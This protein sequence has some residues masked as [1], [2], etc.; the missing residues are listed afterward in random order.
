MSAAA[1]GFYKNYWAGDK[2]KLI[3]G[4]F[5]NNINHLLLLQWLISSGVVQLIVWFFLTECMIKPSAWPAD[6]L[7]NG[8]P[9]E[10][11]IQRQNFSRSSSANVLWKDIFTCF[12]AR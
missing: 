10:D 8:L 12:V 11:F 9:E 1:E 7:Y 3:N 4:P 6:S 2:G 5:I